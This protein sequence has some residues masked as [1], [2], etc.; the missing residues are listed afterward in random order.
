MDES[1][2]TESGVAV[3][4]TASDS[5]PTT[6]ATDTSTRM[7]TSD[8]PLASE[9]YTAKVGRR[10]A[11][12]AYLMGGFQRA[13]MFHDAFGMPVNS[14]G[15][16]PT[17]SERLL[18]GKLQN[19][20]HLETL[21]K[22]LGLRMCITTSSGN[23]IL[24]GKEELESG[25]VTIDLFHREGDLYNPVETLDGLADV[26]VIANGTAVAFGLPMDEADYE[27]FCSNMTKLD[28][29]GKPIVNRCKQAGCEDGALSECDNPFHLIDSSQ[30]VGKV[31]KPANYTPANIAGIIQAEITLIEAQ[32]EG[33]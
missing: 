28:E 20:E 18:R 2:Q 13:G 29:S 14:P 5:A 4:P 31:L 12:A 10:T 6:A 17:V 11:S 8:G 26:K 15:Y 24:V 33:E 16:M 32:Q 22:G 7:N 1:E 21:F 9:I 23:V 25:E 30:P 3:E 27:V 19:E